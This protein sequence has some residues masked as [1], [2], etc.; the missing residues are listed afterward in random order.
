MDSSLLP[1]YH[2]SNSLALPAMQPNKTL[3]NTNFDRCQLGSPKN[4]QER[5]IWTNAIKLSLYD[6]FKHCVN[7]YSLCEFVC[8]ADYSL[9]IKI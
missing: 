7:L 6:T 4:F 1:W 8:F 5:S 3:K 9:K 2:D